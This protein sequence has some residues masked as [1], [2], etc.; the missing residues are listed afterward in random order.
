MWGHRVTKFRAFRSPV[1]IGVAGMAILVAGCSQG[2][3]PAEVAKSAQV[4]AQ[5][6]AHKD[7]IKQQQDA[8]VALKAQ[9]KALKDKAVK[10][11]SVKAAAAKARAAQAAAQAAAAKAAAARAP[12][13]TL[14]QMAGIFGISGHGFGLVKPSEVFNGGDPT[15]LVTKVVWDSWGGPKAVGHGLSVYVGPN[16]TVADGT[17]QPSTIVAFNLGTCDGKFMYRAVKWY[18][19]QHGDVFDPTTYEDVCTGSYVPNP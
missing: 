19:P 11:A 3:S 5:A 12:A 7:A 8:V 16:Q 1:L 9:V 14:G 17:M 4:A 6:Q 15:G 2:A 10:A 18:F 13:P